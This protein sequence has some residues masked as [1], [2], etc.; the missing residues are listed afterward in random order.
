MKK[1]PFFSAGQCLLRRSRD[2]A[3]KDSAALPLRYNLLSDRSFGVL[4][5]FKWR[6]LAMG[7]AVKF[8]FKPPH[9]KLRI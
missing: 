3:V 9:I 5:D 4:S 7:H 2:N 6:F 1:Q 8:I